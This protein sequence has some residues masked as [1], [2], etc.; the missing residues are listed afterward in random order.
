MK[1]SWTKNS[2]DILER[3]T[4]LEHYNHWVASLFKNYFG[5]HILEIGSGLGGLS[6][7][8]PKDKTVLSDSRRDYFN[9][10][11]NRLGYKTLKLNIEIEISKSLINSF[12]TIISSNVFEHIGDDERALKNCFKLL[13]VGGKLLLLVPARPEIFGN[14]DR[15]MGHFRRY[16][17]L[18]LSNKVKKTG[19]KIT[20]IK[21]VNFPGYLSW[22][23]RGRFPSKS[24][25]DILLGKAFDVFV[26][27]FLYFEKYFPVPFGQSLILIAQKP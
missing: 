16:T 21:Y 11:K 6:K 13:K 8:L 9:Y 24:S 19:F 3:A 7:F 5:K 10:L 23:F 27:P 12:D 18:D 14:L 1:K 15:A 26:V 22:W 20:R 17:K 2:H 25:S 4:H